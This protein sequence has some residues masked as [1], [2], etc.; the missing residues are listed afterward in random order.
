MALKPPKPSKIAR[1]HRKSAQRQQTHAEQQM[2][3]DA[4]ARMARSNQQ[5]QA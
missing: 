2:L 5:R 3:K 4:Q 1:N